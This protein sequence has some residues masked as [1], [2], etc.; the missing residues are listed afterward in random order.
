M[1]FTPVR[2]SV[3]AT[4]ANLGS[5]FDVL[6]LALGLHNH[7]TVAPAERTRIE[8]RG[9]GAGRLPLGPR[10]L[11]FRAFQGAFA[12]VGEPA[13]P[14]RV[15]MENDVPPSS[16]LGSSA[17]AIAGGV[18]AARR[19]LAERGVLLSPERC[20]ALAARIEGH[21]DNVA[22]ALFGGLGAV[23]IDA[24]GEGQWLPL[25]YPRELSCALAIPSYEVSTRR[26]RAVLPRRVSRRDA[27]FNLSRA[28]FL[29][30]AL[31]QARWD[32][33]GWGMEDRLHQPHR[34]SLLPGLEA[35]MDAAKAAGAAGSALSGAGP[36]VIA[37]CADPDAELGKTRAIA[38]AMAGAFEREGIKARAVACRPVQR[39]ALAAG[40]DSGALAAGG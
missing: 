32:L 22:P 5:G 19:I 36:T 1:S 10:N 23:A 16:G 7:F 28:V 13:P 26:A 3:P 8:V 21:P 38:E 29:I 35:V 18:A 25:S 15:R 6:G 30:G 2:L 17:T 40:E 34:L 24:G 33:I 39:G 27:V 31:A 9:E 14:V 12:E 11:F 20:L 4:S 37:L